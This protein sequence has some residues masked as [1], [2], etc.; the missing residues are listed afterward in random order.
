ME[1]TYVPEELADDVVRATL[2][3]FKPEVH[4]L[5]G[6]DTIK[7]ERSVTF[8]PSNPNLPVDVANAQGWAVRSFINGYVKG[9]QDY[10]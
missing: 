7:G 8:M 6:P 3:Y 10:P 4:V 5:Q 9:R 2:A 1:I